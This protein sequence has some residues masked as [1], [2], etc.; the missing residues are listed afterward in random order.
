[1]ENWNLRAF[2][3]DTGVVCQKTARTGDM[4]EKTARR[5]KMKRQTLRGIVDN[6]WIGTGEELVG[7]N[8]LEW[9]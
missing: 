1:M 7:R 4:F 2:S 3:S 8:I 5:T 9:P 6:L